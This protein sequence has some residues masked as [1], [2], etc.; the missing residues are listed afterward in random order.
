MAANIGGALFNSSTDKYTPASDIAAHKITS[1]MAVAITAKPTALPSSGGYAFLVISTGQGETEAANGLYAIGIHNVS[2]TNYWT[3]FHESGAGT[4][5]IVDSNIVVGGVGVEQ[6]IVLIRDNS[7]KTMRFVVDGVDGGAFSYSTNPTGGTTS[8]IIIGQSLSPG[9]EFQGTI[10]GLAIWNAALTVAQAQAYNAVYTGGLENLTSFVNDIATANLVSYYPLTD[11]DFAI[12]IIAANHCAG[13][14]VS[15]TDFTTSFTSV[16]MDPNAQ[17]G[18]TTDG[19]YHYISNTTAL[20]K[21]NN[22]GTWSVAASNTSP[23][24][25]L[26]GSPDHIGDICTDGTY[27]Y[28]PV[29]DYPGTSAKQ[30]ARYLCSDLSYHSHITLGSTRGT[31]GVGIDTANGL[32][33]V[34]DYATDVI[35]IYT[36]ALV[37]QSTINITPTHNT[38][39]GITFKNGWL[40]VVASSGALMIVR[41]SN[42]EIVYRKGL[43]SFYEYEGLDYTQDELRYLY[44]SATGSADQKVKYLTDVPFAA[45]VSSSFNAAWARGSNQIIGVNL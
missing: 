14:D 26:S 20:H 44:D 45:A 39:Q 40:Y 7:A 33:Y 34:S 29:D 32:L 3:S 10:K 27:I 5:H 38:I 25:S 19:T 36:T 2:G 12:D 9:Q 6:T 4:N 22:D 1:S 17:Q 31:S 24:A 37:Y 41:P 28:A 16:N 23:F 35:D 15:V 43:G 11:S 42:G 21:R 8:K 30:L 13:T 18:Y